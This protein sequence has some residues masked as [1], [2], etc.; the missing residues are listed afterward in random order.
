MDACLVECMYVCM[1]VLYTGK[2]K[3]GKEIPVKTIQPRNPVSEFTREVKKST[4][5]GIS[6]TSGQPLIYDNV[7]YDEGPNSTQPRTPASEFIRGVKKSSDSGISVES[8]QAPIYDNVLYTEGPKEENA[9]SSYDGG[10]SM[11]SES[12][13]GLIYDNVPQ[14]MGSKKGCT[15]SKTAP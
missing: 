5:S 3:G 4:D 11:G 8:D 7:S 10:I 15:H 14:A 13:Q 12:D 1:H 9:S 6:M 2:P